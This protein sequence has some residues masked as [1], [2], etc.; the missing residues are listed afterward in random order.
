MRAWSAWYEVELHPGGQ[1]NMVLVKIV[2]LE[3]VWLVVIPSEVN[4]PTEVSNDHVV[5]GG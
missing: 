5:K 1:S 3:E 4:H 2:R